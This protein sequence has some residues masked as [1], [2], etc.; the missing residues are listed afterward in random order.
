MKISVPIKSDSWNSYPSGDIDFSINNDGTVSI[1]ID[2]WLDD[3]TP[4]VGRIR[5]ISIDGNDFEAI[6]A[7]RSRRLV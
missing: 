5:E 3:S 7:A 1:F 6:K 2:C 4:S